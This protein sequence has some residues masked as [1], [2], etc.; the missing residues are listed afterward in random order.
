MYRTGE[1]YKIELNTGI[2][3]TGIIIEEE[4]GQILIKTIRNE[5]LILNK[6]EIRRARLLEQNG[7]KNDNK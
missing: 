6:A 4:A 1:S 7:D 5:E 2:F 3:Y